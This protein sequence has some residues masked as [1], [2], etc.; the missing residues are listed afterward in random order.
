MHLD[1]GADSAPFDP[2]DVQVS[3]HGLTMPARWHFEPG[4][5]LAINFQVDAG[6]GRRPRLLKTVGLVV[7]CVPDARTRGVFQLTMWFLETTDD[8]RTL[9]RALRSASSAESPK[10]KARSSKQ[11]PTPKLEKPTGTTG[12]AAGFFEL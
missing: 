3:L 12:D 1:F 9:I 4:T 5:E 8:V 10:S 6:D 11:V 2:R 7:G